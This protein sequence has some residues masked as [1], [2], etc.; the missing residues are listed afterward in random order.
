MN[1]DSRYGGGKTRAAAR[2]QDRKGRA[3]QSLRGERTEPAA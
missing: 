1:D 3:T 2:R